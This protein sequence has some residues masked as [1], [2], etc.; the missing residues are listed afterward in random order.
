MVSY[1]C[2]FIKPHKQHQSCFAQTFFGRTFQ[3]E[4]NTVLAE[5]EALQSSEKAAASEGHRSC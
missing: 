3:L 2:A 4:K 5:A 1:N